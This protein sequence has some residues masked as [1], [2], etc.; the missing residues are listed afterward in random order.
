MTNHTETTTDYQLQASVSDEL[1]WTPE[2]NSAH[3]GVSAEDG[4]VTLSGEVDSYSDRIAA[5]N[6]AL[7]VTGVSV[8]A[9]E[10]IIRTSH[11]STGTDTDLAESVSKVLSWTAGIPQGSVKAEVRDHVVTLTGTVDWNYQRDLA[12][13]VVNG[14][15]GVLRV[16]NSIHLKPRATVLGTESV[17]KAAFIRDATLDANA[18]SVAIH[19]DEATLTG[20]LRS[21]AE[22]SRAGR[23]AW[24]APAVGRI[25]NELTVSS[26]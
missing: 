13:R 12:S 19:G 21:W 7:R 17:I 6:A 25:K 8:V 4:V 16:D 14:I 1:E 15:V 20:T 3:I 11:Q 2:V 5:K 18:I 9:D 26:S 22:K 10:L 24:S 23:A